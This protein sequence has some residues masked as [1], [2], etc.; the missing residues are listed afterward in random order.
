VLRLAQR[1]SLVRPYVRRGARPLGLL[2]L[3]AAGFG[4]AGVRSEAAKQ[5]VP[6]AAN[7]QPAVN[8]WSQTGPHVGI[9]NSLVVAPS[10]PAVLYAGVATTS[11][12]YVGS[13]N[14]SGFFKSTDGGVSWS[15]PG[16]N[17]RN[18]LAV[19][20][21]PNNADTVY[22]GT[23]RQGLFKSTDGG[24]TWAGPYLTI[25][26]L[27]DR[28]V[29]A[30]LVDPQTPSVLYAGVPGNGLYKSTDGGVNWTSISTGLT[31]YSITQLAIDPVNTNNVYAAGGDSSGGVYKSVNGGASWSLSRTGLPSQTVSVSYHIVALDPSN[32]ATVY[33]GTSNMGVYQSTDGGLTWAARNAGLP[34]DEITNLTVSPNNPAL[35]LAGTLHKGIYRST[36][37]GN[38]WSSLALSGTGIRDLRFVSANPALLYAGTN[39]VG[40]YKSSDGG[41][42]WAQS[43]I[44]L[45]LADTARLVIDPSNSAIFYLGASDGLYKS[46][47][48]GQSWSATE[49]MTSVKELVIDPTNPQTLYAGLD[50]VGVYKTTDGGANW[51]RVLGF[52][53]NPFEAMAIDP[54]SP[55]TLYAAA[56]P[57]KLFKTTDGG[58]HWPEIRTPSDVGALFIDGHSA[59]VYAGTIFGLYKSTNAGASWN[60][61]GLSNQ[62]GSNPYVLAIAPDPSDPNT[63]YV[64]TANDGAYKST[65]DG[66]HWH[67][68]FPNV[69]DEVWSIAA[70]PG[71][72][73]TVLLGTDSG[74]YLSNDGGAGASAFNDGLPLAPSP[75]RTLAFDATGSYLYAGNAGGLFVTQLAS[76]SYTIAPTSQTFTAAGGAGTI[77]VTAGTGCAWQT[78]T[79]ATWLMINSGA[80]GAGDGAVGYTVAP[81]TGAARTGTLTVAGQTFTVTQSAGCTY[82]VSPAGPQVFTAAGGQGTLNMSAG[83]GCVWTAGSL[84]PWITITAGA[85]GTGNGVIN[86]TVAPNTGDA[87][88]GQILHTDDSFYPITQAA[89]APTIQFDAPSYR[90][91]EGA[92]QALVNVTR[93]GDTT[94]PV[95]VDFTTVDDLADVGCADTQHN[96]HAAYARC[97]YATTVDTLRFNAGEMSKALAIPL[98]DDAHIEGD[99]TFT[100]RLSN[101]A[102]AALGMQLSATVTIQD[103][104][105]VGQPSPIFATPFFIRQHYLDFLNREPE[106]NEP[107]SNVLNRC[108][109]PNNVDPLSPSAACDRL[110]VSSSFFGS[111][112]FRLKGFYVFLFYRLA[113]VRLPAYSEI[114]PDMRSVTGQTADETFQKKAAFANAF[115]ARTEFA[116]TLGTLSNVE[117]VN[118]LLTR[119]QQS[120]ITT[121]DPQHPDGTVKVTLT[122]AELISQLDAHALTRAQVLRAVVDS[123]EALNLEFNRAFVAMQYYG[124]LRRT[125]EDAGYNAWLNYLNAHP[126]DFRTMVNGFMNSTEYRLRFGPAQ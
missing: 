110:I 118:T 39:G 42:T 47:D 97:D 113:F 101:P 63:L 22:A 91:S 111:P 46:I 20:V 30:L 114:I 67:P 64:G 12:N 79:N 112:E 68:I 45:P 51:T 4:V 36:D 27:F 108:P 90:F 6:A 10:N 87:R 28:D 92:A 16:L 78:T 100:V 107:W 93:A 11:S 53:N 73:G 31:Y 32:P 54:V 29:N 69:T 17:G 119:V 120:A 124:Y 50:Y 19:A 57:F 126:T 9:V 117:Y 2:L 88:N 82:N 72:P 84:A 116:T 65:D 34:N 85:T 123:D 40:V 56:Y 75:V 62:S 102:S 96:N 109:D 52:N 3:L 94:V 58:G 86:F 7:T 37:G 121:P 44:G 21:D 1:L 103:N 98:I 24:A 5:T 38:T 48:R 49:L 105:A 125:P 60:F 70:A 23:Y 122:S 43:S 15:G 80:S 55:N 71:Q 25:G 83:S 106:Q 18:V 95:A 77:N 13:P 89:A 74:V 115:G 33:V 8:T 99:E 81:N 76:C 26:T 104:D 41:A 66:A 35:L 59:T 14:R 61:A